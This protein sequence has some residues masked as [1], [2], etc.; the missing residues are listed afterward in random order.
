MSHFP[1]RPANAL[2][3]S[4]FIASLNKKDFGNR[5]ELIA[6]EILRGNFPNFMRQLVPITVNDKGNA[7]IYYVMPDYLSI[8]NDADY[9]RA[10]LGASAAQTVADAFDCVLPTAK[11]SDQ[12]WQA[13]KVKL[14]P[15]PMSGRTSNISGTQYSPQEFLKQK[16][17]D[18][19]AFLEHNNLIQQQLKNKSPGTLVAGHKKD[20]ILSNEAGPDNVAIYGMHNTSGKPIQGMYTKHA[21]NYRDYSHGIRLVDKKAS[22]NGKQVDLVRDVLQNPEFAYLISSTGPLQVVS[23]SKKSDQ[24]IAKKD[25]PTSTKGRISILDRLTNYLDTLDKSV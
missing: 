9:V 4:Q 24:Q 10:P 6:E 12:I 5:D 19:D 13:A 1:P 17:S 11:M 14:A 15:E 18:T 23:Y 7:L 3:G 25:N 8:G 22:L 2:P 16:M 20:V 21:L